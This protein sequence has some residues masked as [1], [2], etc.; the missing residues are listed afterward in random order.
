M[1]ILA[2]LKMPVFKS[3]GMP[4]ISPAS[5]ALVV[6]GLV[7][8][9]AA[10]GFNDIM[11]WPVST[12]NARLTSVSGFSIRAN[13][14]GVAWA[15][16]LQIASPAPEASHAT[17]QSV[18]NGYATTVALADLA[19]PH[20]LLCHHVDNAPL[21]QAYGAPLRMVI[22]NLWGYKSCKWLGAITFGSKMLGG[23]WEDRGYPR[24]GYIEA[25]QTL[26]INTRT[27]RRHGPGEIEDF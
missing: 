2:D 14:Q 24:E 20:V 27:R 7:A 4:Q 25:G 15:D 5:Y 11:S 22:P 21:D 23:F 3:G 10:H 19:A 9:P 26:D 12:I 1:S 6:K 8:E 16:F 17:F 13:W 18:G